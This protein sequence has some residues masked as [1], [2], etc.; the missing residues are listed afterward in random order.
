MNL[1]VPG[2]DN[3]YWVQFDADGRHQE[4]WISKWPQTSDG[5]PALANAD[6]RAAILAG[7]KSALSN[8]T[9]GGYVTSNFKITE[10][11]ANPA[12]VTP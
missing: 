12:D 7:L 9:I 4:F 6:F 8:V 5:W 2:D 11:T 3:I 1:G 10:F